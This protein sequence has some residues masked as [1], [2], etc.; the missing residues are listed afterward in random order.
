MGSASHRIGAGARQRTQLRGSAWSFWTRR[1]NMPCG[2]VEAVRQL[3]VTR[4][5]NKAG[6]GKRLASA[7]DITSS[8][9][10]VTAPGTF[11][12]LQA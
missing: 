10:V 11:Q 5:V 4:G 12:L 6:G 3:G 7:S 8:R 2:C 1:T 9:A